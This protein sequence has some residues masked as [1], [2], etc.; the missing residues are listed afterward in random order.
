[1]PEDTL[2]E[3]IRSLPPERVSEV[4][5]FVD[6]LKARDQDSALTQGMSRLSEEAF[7]RVWDNPDDADYD[8]L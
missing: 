6:F 7:R 3:K 2:I 5:D 1:M 4:E 8:R